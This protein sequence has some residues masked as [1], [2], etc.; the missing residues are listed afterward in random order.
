M[1][2]VLCYRSCSDKISSASL[3]TRSVDGMKKV[4]FTS[5]PC[6]SRRA[7]GSHVPNVIVVGHT[8]VFVETS[9]TSKAAETAFEI[10]DQGSRCES[11]FAGRPN[12]RAKVYVMV[13]WR[14]IIVRRIGKIGLL[15]VS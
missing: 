13:D 7:E 14:G 2:G 12:A 6:A 9:V 11:L 3:H 15:K 1:F 10:V 5:W 4:E 8:L